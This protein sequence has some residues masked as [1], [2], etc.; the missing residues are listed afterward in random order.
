MDAR[1]KS[2][3]NAQQMSKRV[4][5]KVVYSNCCGAPMYPNSDTCPECKE[6]CEKLSEVDCCKDANDE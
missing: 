2:N 5:V 3:F 1:N 4:N 6:Y